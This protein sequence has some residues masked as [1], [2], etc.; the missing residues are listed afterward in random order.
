M[1]TLTLQQR[2]NSQTRDAW[3][4]FLPHRQRVFQLLARCVPDGAE[5]QRLCVLGA[6]NCNDLDLLELQQF[7]AEISLVDLDREAVLAGIER[8]RAAANEPWRDEALRIIAPCDLAGIAEPLADLKPPLTAAAVDWLRTHLAAASDTAA[9]LGT[10]DVVISTCLLTQL[11]HAV[12][13][14][15]STITP[16]SLRLNIDI[17]QAHLATLLRMTSPGGTS[18]LVSDVVSSLTAPDLS[19]LRQDQL[20]ARLTALV[21]ERNFF[22]GA[23]P[24]SIMIDL[25]NQPGLKTRPHQIS[26]Y[27]PWLWQLLPDRCYLVWAVG[28]KFG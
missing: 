22:T 12:I 18:I 19:T 24:R 6:G 16:E 15:D 28:I 14:W 25:V 23:N 5:N 2:H 4:R 21:A 17:R 3:E 13:A 26:E 20:P 11:F 7:F 10:F 9:A 27:D 1:N 8:Q